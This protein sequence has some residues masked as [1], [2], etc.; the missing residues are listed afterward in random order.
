VRRAWCATT[1]RRT[2]SSS[3][4]RRGIVGPTATSSASRPDRA[5]LPLVAA[6][7]AAIGRRASRCR[8]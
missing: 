7:G 5:A 3:A 8:R 2:R 1:S 6:S 4:C